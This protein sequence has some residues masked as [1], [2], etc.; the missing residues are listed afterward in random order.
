MSP[1]GQ[2]TKP[3][4]LHNASHRRWSGIRERN[5]GT[6]KPLALNGTP[7]M[8]LASHHYEY[9]PAEHRL[10]P[11]RYAWT[12]FAI[13]FALMVVDYVDRQVVVSMFP[14]LKAAVEPLRR[15]A[16][17]ARVDRVDHRRARRRP[18]VAAR[19]PLEPRQEHLPDGAGLEPRDDRLR[20][21]GELRASCSAR[22][23]VVG[24]GEAAY[25]T[26][27]AAL[28]ATPVPG[29]HAQL[30]ARRVL[31]RRHPRLGAGRRARRRH[32]RAL[33]LAGGLRRGRH[34]RAA[35]S[36]FVFLF[37]RARLQDGR[38][39]RRGRRRRP[40]HASRRAPSWPR[41]CGRAP[42]SSRASAPASSS[43][44]C[45]RPTRGCR[46]YFNRFY[47]L[48]PDQAGLKAGLVVLV[49]GVGAVAL[50][51]RRGPADAAH[52]RAPAC[53]FPR[54]ARC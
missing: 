35:S 32:R 40:R 30:G 47:G 23:R 6:R 12:V 34:P 18:A 14:H 29:A 28:L 37:D 27:G 15:P 2:S 24:V 49:G 26:V 39:A 51:H 7:T 45:R 44:W 9:D 17:R 43:S 46:R 3:V 16:R 8:A 38:A 22:A 11:R 10:A 1:R 5:A 21:R 25:G 48:A 31:R 36:P 33:G 42:R 54:S 50:G 20:V 13:L 4:A 19:R 53:T 41:C 52:P